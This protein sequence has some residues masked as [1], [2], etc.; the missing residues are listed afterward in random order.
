MAEMIAKMAVRFMVCVVEGVVKGCWR[1]RSPREADGQ[2]EVKQQ[3]KT[4][5]GS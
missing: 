5:C 3:K 4:V 1:C 2:E